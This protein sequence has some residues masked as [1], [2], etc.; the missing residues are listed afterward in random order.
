MKKKA[1]YFLLVLLL[2]LSM[3]LN[4]ATIIYNYSGLWQA[5]DGDVNEIKWDLL[6]DLTQDFS[7]Y[8]SD[9][10]KTNTLLVLDKNNNI[11]L[12]QTIYF[13][14]VGSDWY[15]GLSLGSQ[16]LNL[17][18]TSQP[19]YYILFSM[20]GNNFIDTYNVKELEKDKTYNLI[21]TSGNYK[22]V[23]TQIDA[24]MPVGGPPPVPLP[25]SALLL[26]SGLLGLALVWRRQQRRR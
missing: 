12:A 23:F 13:T 14:K 5:N 24:A 22:D 18:S 3:P 8:I 11:Q 20:D 26:G 10:N 15:A 19:Q 17:G 9:P 4:A 25:G 7:L 16:S 1:T 6:F 2:G 21:V